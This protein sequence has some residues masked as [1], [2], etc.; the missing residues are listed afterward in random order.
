[1]AKRRVMEWEAGRC[2]RF[3]GASAPVANEEN[4]E[5]GLFGGGGR[6]RAR[7]RRQRGAEHTAQ[8]GGGGEG[9]RTVRAGGWS[10][11]R[12][13]APVLDQHDEGELL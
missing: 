11:C 4:F 3:K 12:P 6:R 7:R 2:K 13:A 8:H 9:G 1:M 10:C 5:R